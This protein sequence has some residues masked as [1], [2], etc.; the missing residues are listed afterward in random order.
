MDEIT[1]RSNRAVGGAILID[2]AKWERLAIIG[3]NYPASLVMKT[4]NEIKET[5]KRNE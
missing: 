3:G 2:A 4:V 5:R 1:H